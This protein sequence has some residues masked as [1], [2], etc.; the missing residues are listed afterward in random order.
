MTSRE[1]FI[2]EVK[3]KNWIRYIITIRCRKVVTRRTSNVEK[4]NNNLSLKDA[5]KKKKERNKI[6]NIQI[7]DGSPSKIYGASIFHDG[8]KKGSMENRSIGRL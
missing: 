6:R 2:L 1:K 8:R 3:D 7:L 4:T 5:E